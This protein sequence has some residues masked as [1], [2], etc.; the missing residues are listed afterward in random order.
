MKRF[1]GLPNQPLYEAH[2]GKHVVIGQLAPA[3]AF[4]LVRQPLEALGIRIPDKLVQRILAYCNYHPKLLQL[5]GQALVQAS[6][7]TR[8]APPPSPGTPPGHVDNTILKRVIGSQDLTDR[9][10][11]TISLT[12]ELDPRYKLIA[13]IVVLASPRRGRGPA[14]NHPGPGQGMRRLVATGVHR[15]EARR[16]PW[17]AGGMIGLG[18]LAGDPQGWRLRSSNIPRLLGNQ[19]A[20]EEA[21]ENHDTSKPLTKLTAAQ[22]RRP[23]AADI[24]ISPLTEQQLARLT[25][26]GNELRIVIDRG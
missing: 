21:L 20:I 16:V 14:D 17:A 12:L 11:N 9:T 22:A 4:R 15:P 5:A 23:I 13:L 7:N 19:H 26:P 2:F 8:V 24:R 18:V 6:L 25:T 10:R 1:S 3:S